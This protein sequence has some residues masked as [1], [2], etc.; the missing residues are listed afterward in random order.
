[1]PG[2]VKSKEGKKKR[3]QGRRREAT[4][5]GVREL[6][7]VMKDGKGEWIMG[8]GIRKCRNKEQESKEEDMLERERGRKREEGKEIRR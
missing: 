2:G 4:Q 7:S 3:R 6:K 1:M 8:K 5:R